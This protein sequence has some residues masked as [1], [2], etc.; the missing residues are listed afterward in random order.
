MRLMN[1]VVLPMY[2][3]VLQKVAYTDSQVYGAVLGVLEVRCGPFWSGDH[4]SYKFYDMSI[5]LKTLKYI[6]LYK[7]IKHLLCL[8]LREGFQMGGSKGDDYSVL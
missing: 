1:S 3:V 6:F 7:Q 8:L 4:T 5:P 2:Y